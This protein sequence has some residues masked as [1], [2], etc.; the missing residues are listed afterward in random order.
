MEY[1]AHHLPQSIV[2]V[3]KEWSH[4]STPTYVFMEWCLIQQ[5]DTFIVLYY[6]DLRFPLF[7]NSKLM[8]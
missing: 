8:T 6:E 2:E 5:K 7:D 1:E 3:Q 4:T